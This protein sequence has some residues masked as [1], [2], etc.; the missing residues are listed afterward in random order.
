MDEAYCTPTEN[1]VKLA[2]RTQQII[3]HETGIADTIDP[4]GGS[5]YVETLTNSLEDEARKYVEEIERIGGVIKAIESGYFQEKIGESSYRQQRQIERK[6]KIIVGMNEFVDGEELPVQIFRPP[7]D[8]AEK[9]KKKL[10]KL[11]ETRD[12]Q[13]VNETLRELERLAGTNENLVPTL[14]Q[15]VNSYA[16]VGEICDVFRRVFGE[17]RETKFY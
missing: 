6:E 7:E 14:I 3:A 8:T 10:R 2:L 12:K 1:S 13:K 15:A 17:Y 16:T 11:R 9:Q 4:L 5:Y